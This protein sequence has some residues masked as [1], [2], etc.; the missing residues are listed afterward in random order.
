M[1]RLKEVRKNQ[2]FT[3]DEVVKE[4]PTISKTML[5]MYERGGS[6]VKPEKWEELAQFYDVS[7]PYLMGH[8]VEQRELNLEDIK[9]ALYDL[10]HKE[11]GNSLSDQNENKDRILMLLSI[12]QS[13]N[14]VE[15]IENNGER[16]KDGNNLDAHFFS[17][18]ADECTA[19]HLACLREEQASGEHPE[20]NRDKINVLTYN[21]LEKTKRR[22]TNKKSTKN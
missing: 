12:A 13:L 8:D 15:E 4:L 9:K 22:W 6:N 16:D 5:S 11:R 18:L 21:H 14:V 1:N 10:I 19:L 7:V 2:G 17:D 20:L 3:L